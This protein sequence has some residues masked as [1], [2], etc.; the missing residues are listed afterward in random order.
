MTPTK[1]NFGLEE[2][3]ALQREIKIT[4]RDS[5]TIALICR[6]TG[7]KNTVVSDT[8]DAVSKCVE[9]L[10]DGKNRINKL[11]TLDKDD[12]KKTK[13]EVKVLKTKHQVASRGWKRDINTEEVIIK[14]NNK[15][16]K[17]FE[18]ILNNFK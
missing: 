5:R 11:K 6:V 10:R 2:Y 4:K 13:Q 7:M 16:K 12:H 8:K 17:S 1:E 14:V 18:R 9:A 3:E 15:D